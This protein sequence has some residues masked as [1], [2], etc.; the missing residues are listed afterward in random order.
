[1][2]DSHCVMKAS[3]I[4][5]QGKIVAT[6]HARETVSKSPINKFAFVEN[7]VPLDTKILTRNGWKF[8]YQVREGEDVLSLNMETQ[9]VEFC[10][11]LKINYY[12]NRPLV[13]LKT[14]R[15]NV[16]CT[17]GH[18]W[19]VRMQYHQKPFK[20]STEELKQHHQILQN[21]PQSYTPSIMG[22]KLGWLMCDCEINRT[23]NGLVMD[24]DIN[25]SKY[26]DDITE[27]V[28]TYNLF[29]S[30]K[31]KKHTNIMIIGKTIINGLF[32]PKK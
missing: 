11:I 10:K 30:A 31:E 26:V 32:L 1:M 29:D 12:E 20:V 15:F 9:K 21:I 19:V 27:F 14:R 24:A 23:Q 7:C 8:Y 6:G 28:S 5:P 17:P 13:N 4:D 25:Q 18:K 16:T 3:V 22:R 2:S